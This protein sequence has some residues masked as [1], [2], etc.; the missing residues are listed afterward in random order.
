MTSCWNANLLPTCSNV[1]GFNPGALVTSG[2][3][4]FLTTLNTHSGAEGD[5]VYTIWSKADTVVGAQCIVYGKVTCRIP[6][7]KAEVVKTTYDHF[8]VRDKTGPDMIKWL[9]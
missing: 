6:G 7:Q 2:P 4:K 9:S 1:D 5:N 3:S 8:D